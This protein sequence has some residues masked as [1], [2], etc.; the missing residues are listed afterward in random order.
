MRQQPLF[1]PLISLT[2]TVFA[3]AVALADLW[4]EKLI[5]GELDPAEQ[6]TGVIGCCHTFLFR[7]TEII[8]RDQHLDIA[9]NLY[10]G[11]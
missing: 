9:Y 6:L 3:T 1:L 11:K 5:G 4:R 8:R 7:D 10:N 2:W